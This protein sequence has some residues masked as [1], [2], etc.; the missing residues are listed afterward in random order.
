M[1]DVPAFPMPHGTHQE[2]YW[3]LKPQGIEWDYVVKKM[4]IN[5]FHDAKIPISTM[6]FMVE[7][8]GTYWLL[9]RAYLSVETLAKH[10]GITEKRLNE[11]KVIE[12]TVKERPDLPN[13]TVSD[14]GEA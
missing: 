6:V 9:H 7:G 14:W 4:I 5:N 12:L 10:T 2:D 3:V 8:G 1:T 11:S 13:P